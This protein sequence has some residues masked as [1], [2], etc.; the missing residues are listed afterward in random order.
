MRRFD[1]GIVLNE[2]DHTQVVPLLIRSQNQ[3]QMGD[4][5][6]AIADSRANPICQSSQQLISIEWLFALEAC[7]SVYPAQK[8]LSL[9]VGVV[10]HFHR[11]HS[12]ARGSTEK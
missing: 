1:S 10:V 9:G 3:L 8:R 12:A 4:F 2:V 7:C 6:N 11:N 5:A